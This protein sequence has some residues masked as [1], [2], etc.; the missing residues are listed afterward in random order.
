MRS[1]SLQHYLVEYKD[2]QLYYFYLDQNKQ[3]I[4]NIYKEDNRLVT[5]NEMVA[6][7]IST[8]SVD[9]DTQNKIH[10]ICITQEGELRYY[11]YQNQHWDYRIISKLDIR[12]NIYRYLSIFVKGRYTHVFCTKTNLLN[13]MVSSIEHMYWDDKGI[14][15]STMTTYLHGKYPSPYQIVVDSGD[16]LY[17]LYKVFYKSNYQF[18]FSKFNILHKK[19]TSGE[20]ITNSQEDHSH[21]HMLIDRNHTLHI[22]WCS[23]EENNFIIKYKRKP[24]VSRSKSKWSRLYTLT[25]RNA[26]HLSPVIMENE[27]KLMVFSMQNQHINEIYSKD[28]GE[29]W[30]AVEKST[31]HKLEDPILMKYCQLNPSESNYSVNSIY[32][33]AENQLILLGLRTKN[34][35]STE[36]FKKKPPNTKSE[37][38]KSTEAQDPP[39]LKTHTDPPEDMDMDSNQNPEKVTEE[40]I[41]PP[42]H[43]QY[44]TTDEN[45]KKLITEVQDYINKIVV[46]IDKID[47]IKGD[48][49]NELSP[50]M[51]S[52]SSTISIDSLSHELKKVGSQL[53]EL[54]HEKF[55]LQREVETCQ[56]KLCQ[57]EDKFIE[58]KK[59]LLTLQEEICDYSCNDPSI[60]N[61]IKTFFK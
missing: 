12:S 13:A 41:K 48:L 38:L 18:Y 44:V 50:N 51:N 57:I 3:I 37:T 22:V 52:H 7:N 30:S 24:Q 58:L 31:L 25:N 15:K 35:V 9:I 21:P 56:K 27:E 5:Q 26:N 39:P 49:D 33:E 40:A 60:L 34:P 53:T 1:T 11:I 54:D 17:I 45:F 59:S 14:N 23:L 10:L 36:T 42:I 55:L 6:T 47:N 2:N 20:L 19:W 29:T 16:N 43:E 28:F 46:E 32:G 61:R 4:S 8:F